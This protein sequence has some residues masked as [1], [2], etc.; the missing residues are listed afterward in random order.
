MGH[1]SHQTQP[2]NIASTAQDLTQ[3]AELLV[4][5]GRLGEALDASQAATLMYQRSLG[6]SS[7]SH[8]EVPQCKCDVTKMSPGTMVP[9]NH[10]D[11]T[12]D[13]SQKLVWQKRH[14]WA[15]DILGINGIGHV[16]KMLR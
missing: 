10:R 15:S 11:R 7:S 14:E 6:L 5:L 8:N 13:S 1:V 9:N 2:R 16:F 4:G 12:R 3:L